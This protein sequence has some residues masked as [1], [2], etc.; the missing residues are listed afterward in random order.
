MVI[1][2]DLHFCYLMRRYIRESDHPLLFSNPDEKAIE[3]AQRE[4]PALIVLESGLPNTIGR[5]V[6]K[7]LKTHQDTCDIP[8]VL[9]SWHEDETHSC[10]EGA[11]IYLRMP[12]LYG[13]FLKILA[14]LGV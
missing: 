11:D 8:V 7:T 2:T 13:D 4:K 12:I 14:N 9:C 5:Q 6:L 3:I 10:E 1:G